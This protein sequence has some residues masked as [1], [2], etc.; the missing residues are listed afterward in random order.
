LLG[1]KL[2]MLQQGMGC[3]HRHRAARADCHDAIVGLNDIPVSAQ[4]KRML[5]VGYQ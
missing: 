4:Q 3:G 5:G 2:G 1:R